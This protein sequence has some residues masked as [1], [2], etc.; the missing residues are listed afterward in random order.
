M[1]LSCALSL[2]LLNRFANYRATLLE[3]SRAT[4]GFADAM[5]TCAGYVSHAGL[6]IPLA[7]FARRLKGPTYESGTR[8]QAA[9]GLHHLMSNHFHVMVSSKLVCQSSVRTLL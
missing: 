5:E 9:A 7:H 2:Q 4:A 3:M 6:T 8:I 1:K